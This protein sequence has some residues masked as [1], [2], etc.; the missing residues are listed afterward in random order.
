M[1]A[2]D[3]SMNTSALNS[4]TGMWILAL[5]LLGLASMAW[6]TV[7]EASLYETRSAIRN[8]RRRRKAAVPRHERITALSR[9]NLFVRS[10]LRGSDILEPFQD[11]LGDR[12]AIDTL[13]L[14]REIDKLVGKD[15]YHGQKEQLK[16]PSRPTSD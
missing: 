14:R 5:F 9:A 12:Q 3:I 11:V 1:Y 15:V 4:Q 16:P 13:R 2:A 8:L 6:L 10:L 7:R